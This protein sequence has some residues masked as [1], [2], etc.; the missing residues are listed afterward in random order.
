MPSLLNLPLNFGPELAGVPYLDQ[1]FGVW[2]LREDCAEALFERAKNI[3][4]QLHLEQHAGEQAAAGGG[5]GRGSDLYVDDNGIAHIEL[6]GTLMKHYSSMAAGTSMVMARRQVRAAMNSPDVLGIMLHIDSPGGTV[7]GT[8]DLGNDIATAASKKPVFAFIEDLG[9]SGAYWLASQAT[10]IS[11]TPTTYVGSIGVFTVAVDSSK[12][13]EAA[14]RK[15][16][17]IRF[18]AMKGAGTPGTPVTDEQRAELQARVDSFGQ[19][20][21]NAIAKGRGMNA[22]AAAAL[23]DGRVHK[24][25]DAKKLGLV[26]SIETID[27]TYAALFAATRKNNPSS[28]GKPM[29]KDNAAELAVA[30]ELK[31]AAAT[32]ADLRENCVGASDAFILSQLEKGAT[33]SQ[34]LKAHAGEMAKANEALAKERDDFK[35]KADAAAAAKPEKP[36]PARG[37][38]P[39]KNA[40]EEVAADGAAWSDLG[41]NEFARIAIEDRVAKGQPRAKAA[42]AVFATHPGLADAMVAEAEEARPARR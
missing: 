9:A 42:K 21:V 39:L 40:S 10:R 37:I 29:S 36:A 15:V 24:G 20:F 26:D 19:D 14:G 3:N 38:Q 23:A 18:G 30:G 28:K 33:V 4:L 16:E 32:I 41:A 6:S 2:A 22:A 34:A 25:T 8:A 13:E 17:V 12:E 5:R 1:Y 27:D 35:A 11:A 7:A 31:P